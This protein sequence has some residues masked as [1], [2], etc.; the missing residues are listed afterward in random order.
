M[1][2][3]LVTFPT[4]L[5][6]LSAIALAD[7]P[8]RP[9]IKDGVITWTDE[10]GHVRK[11]EAGARCADLWV[12]PDGKTIAFVVLG[13]VVPPSGSLLPWERGTVM[14]E[15]SS[16]YI[17]HLREQFSP[18]RVVSGSFRLGLPNAETSSIARSPSVSQDGSTVFFIVPS[19][20]ATG[21]LMSKSLRTGELRS[22]VD[23]VTYCP[24]WGGSASA[25]L[26]LMRRHQGPTIEYWCV[27]SDGHGGLTTLDKG[28]CM[29]N[30]FGPKW[31]ATK[32][33]VCELPAS[34]DWVVPR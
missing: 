8:T 25:D 19:G 24:L 4:V 23:V 6:F 30:I 5:W 33:A 27:L 29:L 26:L 28:D 17:A 34:D 14:I 31:S 11:I 1:T 12:S 21:L 22:L 32:G 16:I 20:G 2:K 9:S 15:S 3:H 18:V 10:G 7:E 13:Q